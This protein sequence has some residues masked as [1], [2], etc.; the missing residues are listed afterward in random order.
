MTSTTAYQFLKGKV[1]LVTGSSRGIGRGIAFEL[2]RRG[3]DVV[4]NYRVNTEA[5]N[6]IVEEIT[7]MGRKA[8]GLKANMAHPQDIV[9]LFGQ[10]SERMGGLDILVVNAGTGRRSTA[11]EMPPKDLNLVL[12][13]NLVG[14]WL[15]VR[16]AVPLMKRRG[17]GRIVF[18][19]T[20]TTL[21][22]VADY[23]SIA[24]SKAAL[25]ALVKYLAVEL[26]R[27]KVIVN[28]V[29]PGAVLTDGLRYWLSEE[30]MN[31]WIARTPQKR[32]VQPSEV[33]N[34]VAFLCSEEA[35]MICGQ[36]IAI[37]GGYYL[38]AT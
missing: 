25:D 35:A 38:P 13:T 22:V 20:S 16:E 28:A 27:E 4:V 18:V 37:D 19:T 21:R 12:S 3:A 36:V 33:G 31:H 26:A 7:A 24:A 32:F 34:L 15:C 1:A 5:A 11:V 8:V 2:A 9:M 29:A 10:I 14:A 6:H 23:S 17:G 30:E